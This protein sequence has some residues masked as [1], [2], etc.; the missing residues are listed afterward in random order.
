LKSDFQQLPAYFV[1]D[2]SRMRRD[3][4]IV[5]ELSPLFKKAYFS[6]LVGDIGENRHPI[7]LVIAK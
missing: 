7:F 4:N 1:M 2:K 3:L 6:R 5:D